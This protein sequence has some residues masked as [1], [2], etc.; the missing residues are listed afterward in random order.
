M[1]KESVGELYLSLGIDL[2]KLESDYLKADE[3]VSQ[4]MRR[5]QNEIKNTKLQIKV[6]TGN[7]N[8]SEADKLLK[9]QQNI[10]TQIDLQ[11]EKV[12]LATAAWRAEVQATNEESAAAMKLQ[13]NMMREQ[14][15][16]QGMQ[17]K[18][19]EADLALLAR[20]RAGNVAT[21]TESGLSSQLA[22]SAGL[23]ETMIGT[24]FI[25]PII[26]AMKGNGWISD[27]S[28]A[29]KK[30]WQESYQKAPINPLNGLE[31]KDKKLYDMYA[32]YN[33]LQEEAK[34]Q[35][36]QRFSQKNAFEQMRLDD[37]QKASLAELVAQEKVY[38]QYHS[39]VTAELQKQNSILSVM[40]KIPVNLGRMIGAGAGEKYADAVYAQKMAEAK[41]GVLDFFG[42]RHGKNEQQRYEVWGGEPENEELLFSGVEEQ[43][44]W[45]KQYIKSK[46]MASV[47]QFFRPEYSLAMSAYDKMSGI[48]PSIDLSGVKE[49]LTSQLSVLSRELKQS[50]I[51]SIVPEIKMPDSRLLDVFRGKISEVGEYLSNG[52]LK[53]G[54]EV[55]GKAVDYLM[56]VLGRGARLTGVAVV[57]AG[58]GEAIVKLAHPAIEAGEAIYRLQQHMHAST[59]DAVG[60]NNLFKISGGSAESTLTSLMR[61]DKSIRTAGSGGNEA[62]RALAAFGVRL[63]SDSGVLLPYNQQ[64]EKLAQGYQKAKA[65]GLEEEYA[66]ATL[67]V[68]GREMISI[69]EDYTE[70]QEKASQIK[71]TGMIN[72][73][74]AHEL[75]HESNL[76]SAEWGQL[77]TAFSAALQPAA[78]E[79]L[80]SLIALL[81][82][83]VTLIS[84]HKEAVFAVST[85]LGKL[86]SMGIDFL[87]GC[88]KLLNGVCNLIG[89][90]ADGIM[91]ITASLEGFDNSAVDSFYEKLKKI[92]HLTGEAKS[93]NP[94]DEDA[95]QNALAVMNASNANKN[96][97]NRYVTDSQGNS[98]NLGPKPEEEK[99]SSSRSA[100]SEESRAAQEAQR[101]E[102]EAY[103]AWVQSHNRGVQMIDQAN[104]IMFHNEH[105][106]MHTAQGDYENAVYDVKLWEWQTQQTAKSAEEAAAVHQ[107]AAA[108]MAQAY[109]AVADKI[110][111]L[112]DS[113]KDKIFKL[114]H[115]DYENKMYDLNK[116]VAE[117]RRQGA[118]E[119]LIRD[120]YSASVSKMNKE[121]DEQ[122]RKENG[123][124]DRYGVT[125]MPFTNAAHAAYGGHD[126]YWVDNNNRNNNDSAQKQPQTQ[127]QVNVTVNVNDA[128]MDNDSNISKVTDKVA[129]KVSR[130]I[131]SVV[132]NRQAAYGR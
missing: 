71:G 113:L 83:S 35:P 85:A 102:A 58:I 32:R 9:L 41:R 63:Q 117:M 42:A 114:T 81:Q 80:P 39:E 18:Q 100:A 95:Q 129:E 92:V 59:A 48:M 125:Y 33:A 116:E 123:Y 26:A 112:N 82:E 50:Q 54:S 14:I 130:Q 77:G 29:M 57:M 126:G 78:A 52:P 16:L 64:L 11:R 44:A 131:Q 115:D 30:K 70:L 40:S 46:K 45:M 20:Q 76:L 90:C 4:N 38:A 66:T 94:I 97:G 67:G 109:Q 61:L 10:N 24:S 122:Y 56:T 104:Q 62:T 111:S 65:A 13:Q 27:V 7:V 86:I 74:M 96:D 1:A 34:K 120:Y 28:D 23:I 68:R 119:G 19:R 21:T 15:S 8:L 55:A 99:T 103:N 69:L 5:L 89:L 84:D 127:Q 110:K 3:T 12:E 79:I 107:L 91:R 51:F 124:T 53:T 37:A 36:G 132:N 49:K 108:K 43:A 121:Y 98:Y 88:I 87:T 22:N 47:P 25:S 6:D 118:N 128:W 106:Y 93:I 73:E 72:P 101:Q 31:E 17:S 2:S 75:E 105:Q 60:F